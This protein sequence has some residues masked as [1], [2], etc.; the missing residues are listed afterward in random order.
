MQ[1]PTTDGTR[2]LIERIEE[3]ERSLARRAER[4]RATRRWL[5]AGVALCAGAVVL[6]ATVPTPSTAQIPSDGDTVRAR[7]V[8]VLNRQGIPVITLGSRNDGAWIHMTDRFGQT[9]A[10]FIGDDMG[11]SR[12]TLQAH[13][14]RPGVVLS[15]DDGGGDVAAFGADGG[16][17]T[18]PLSSS[19]NPRLDDPRPEASE[20]LRPSGV[21]GGLGFLDPLPEEWTEP[22][23]Q[24][25]AQREDPASP[26][27][28]ADRALEH[29]S[30]DPLSWFVGRRLTID[31]TAVPIV[32]ARWVREHAEAGDSDR[33]TEL[34]D[35]YT[36]RFLEM[37]TELEIRE[38]GTWTATDRSGPGAGL[39]REFSGIWTRGRERL[40]LT[41]GQTDAE[42]PD[43]VLVLREPGG[44]LLIPAVASSRPGLPLRAR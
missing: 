2:S 1:I 15:A 7:Q 28:R 21:A 13:P 18:A 32:V 14:D 27:P 38:D 16:R 20:P 25:E 44:V 24:D 17:T 6:G 31:R 34:L 11:S 40:S 35:H 9:R 22:E 37:R 30:D 3:L 43:F 23:P 41:V 12:M 42:S 19:P 5:F 39:G 29:A 33:R 8:M 4:D 26:D 36:Q 10:E